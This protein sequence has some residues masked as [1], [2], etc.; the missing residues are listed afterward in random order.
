MMAVTEICTEMMATSTDEKMWYKD[1]TI[2]VPELRS[3]GSHCDLLTHG[4]KKYSPVK[5]I[6]VSAAILCTGTDA[7]AMLSCIFTGLRQLVVAR[8]DPLLSRFQQGV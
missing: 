2:T 6:I 7:A 1:S 8:I 3:I 4:D 5:K